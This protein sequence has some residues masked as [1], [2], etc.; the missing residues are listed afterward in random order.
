MVQYVMDAG[1]GCYDWN[2]HAK[3][4]I[5]LKLKLIIPACHIDHIGDFKHRLESNTFLTNIPSLATRVALLC[6]LA[7]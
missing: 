4:R 3:L 2:D 6:A 5:P 7:N 1:K